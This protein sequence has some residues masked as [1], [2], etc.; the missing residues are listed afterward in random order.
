MPRSTIKLGLFERVL[1]FFGFMIVTGGMIGTIAWLSSLQG[2]KPI[3]VDRPV[4][5]PAGPVKALPKLEPKPLAVETPKP[6]AVVT[7][8]TKP[9]ETVVKVEPAK[10]VEVAVAPAP[11]KPQAAGPRPYALPLISAKVITSVGDA[12]D[13]QPYR[14]HVKIDPAEIELL[15][16][17]LTQAARQNNYQ[18]DEFDHI[19][20][21]PK[22]GELS[23]W[24]PQRLIDV[25]V[26]AL[27]PESDS[28]AK[29]WAAVS[30]KTGD[31]LVYSI[32]PMDFTRHAEARTGE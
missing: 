1:L 31:V 22:A 5:K 7:P 25:N 10:V 15:R 9:A 4:A 24:Q 2:P 14:Y 16:A 21:E 18:V 19:A 17:L 23:W 8:T 32:K 27:S 13:D 20:A 29:I 28:T 26:I 30:A 6:V 12:N 11:A 3:A